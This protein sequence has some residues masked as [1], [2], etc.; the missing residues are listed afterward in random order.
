MPR[1]LTLTALTAVLATTAAIT[2]AGSGAGASTVTAY[3]G[4][5]GGSQIKAADLRVT[6]ELTSESTV[7]GTTKDA[8]QNNST[9]G[10]H[11]GGVLQ[12]NAVSTSAK[13]ASVSGGRS[14]SSSAQ[15]TGIN[16]LNGLITADAVTTTSTSSIVHGV[17]ASA[18][19]TSFLNL[20]IAGVKLPVNIP[21]NYGVTIP[22]VATVIVNMSI[23]GTKGLTT[24]SIGAGLGVTLLKPAGQNAA[25]AE[26]YV[27]PTFSSAATSNS[28]D[29]GHRIAGLAY[30]TK[31][32][33]G[34]GSTVDVSS[35]PTDPVAVPAVGTGGTVQTRSLLGVHLAPIAT[36]GGVQTTYQ[37]TNTTAVA[38]SATTA[39]IATTSLLGGL[40]RVGALTASAHATFPT[41]GAIDLRGG[42]QIASLTIAGKAIPLVLSPN[43]VI[44]LGKLGAITINAQT[45]TGN[46]I[47]VVALQ[48]KLSTAAYGL[49]AGSLIQVGV[50]S[51]I[52][53]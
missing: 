18:A 11:V 47:T 7:S 26:V 32:V 38:D 12:A 31:I 13:L 35:D 40:I 14:V 37:G 20:K 45:T 22:G 51:V 27:S 9:V 53:D 10:L 19:H 17:Y 52:V 6:S 34:V 33:A 8:S 23:G 24:T 41:G 2:V 28:P 42:T 15:T 39:S 50:A 21:T 30:G 25:G 44:S 1:T 3:F 36:V 29:T 43:T 5:A 48:L 46:A 16:V 4:Y 49:A